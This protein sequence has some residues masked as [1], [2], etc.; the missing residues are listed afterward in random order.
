MK[1][2]GT[3]VRS[4]EFTPSI[5]ARRLERIVQYT[6][7][8]DDA[9]LPVLIDICAEEITE[10]LRASIPNQ[11][12]FS[13][14]V[15]ARG[16][17][18]A[19]YAARMSMKDFPTGK[20]LLCNYICDAWLGCKDED[21]EFFANILRT[22]PES[23]T[24]RAADILRKVISFRFPK[25]DSRTESASGRLSRLFGTDTP[26]IR[27]DMYRTVM[28]ALGRYAPPNDLMLIGRVFA[29]LNGP[30][31]ADIERALCAIAEPP[32]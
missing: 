18:A 27:Y 24:D 20:A 23:E 11:Y 9:S 31:R 8:K 10:S 29:A 19:G 14:S 15:T 30:Q 6:L 32:K 17:W 25:E 12:C 5:A 1:M 13:V 4:T 21:E 2:I 26:L 3:E 16:R 22:W 7:A 28:K